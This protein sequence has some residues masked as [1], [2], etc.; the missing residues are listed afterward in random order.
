MIHMFDD[1]D[2]GRSRGRSLPAKQACSM[3]SM[4]ASLGG[5]QAPKGSF[6]WPKLPTVRKDIPLTK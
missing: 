3:M 4:T 6:V 1:V 2:D 5:R